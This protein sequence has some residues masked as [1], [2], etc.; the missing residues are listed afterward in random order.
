MGL[1]EKESA[2]SMTHIQPHACPVCSGAQTTV[3]E[4]RLNVPTLQNVTPPDLNRAQSFS[5]GVLTM[6]HCGGRGF[7]WDASF[8]PQRISYDGGYNNDVSASGFYQ[9]HLCEMADKILAAVPADQDIHYVEIGCGEGDFLRLLHARSKGRVK[10]AV[11]FDPSCTTEKP[12]PEGAVIH[13]RYFTL[14]DVAKIP[15]QANVICSRHT[16]EH[17]KDVQSFAASLAAA[18]AP[19]RKLFVETP[20]VDWILRHGAFQDFFYEHCALY[21]PVS[22][23]MLFAAHGLQAQ[24]IPVYDEQYMWIEAVQSNPTASNVAEASTTGDQA[25]DLGER[26]L[27]RRNALL[28]RWAEYLKARR[29]AGG[30]AE[31]GAASKGVTFCLLV[32]ARAGDLIDMGIN[33]NPAK[34]QCFM[35]VSVTPIVDPATAMTQG[36]KTVVIMNPN[37]EAEIRSQ[38]AQMGWQAEVSVLNEAEETVNLPDLQPGNW[39]TRQSVS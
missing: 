33:L 26:Y 17:V 5:R 34:Q 11:G 35:P 38:I 36:V 20:D 21:N 12:L 7:V 9:A 27:L 4:R 23:Q 31:W 2:I 29:A 22:I 15:S 28:G 1:L 13:P 25:S 3:I 8:D 6:V 16:I 10:S 24:V 19:G 37:Y 14:E 30:V 32:N 39:G 18:M